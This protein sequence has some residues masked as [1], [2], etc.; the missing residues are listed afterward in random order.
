MANPM[1]SA[2]RA[3]GSIQNLSGLRVSL[4]GA[5]RVGSSLAHWLVARGARMLSI[6]SASPGSAGRLAAE[7]GGEPCAAAGLATGDADLLLVAVPDQALDQAAAELGSRPQAAVALHV[8]GSR[9]ASVL[10]PLRA[11][12]PAGDGARGSAVGTFHPLMAFPTVRRDPRD[13]EGLVFG[14]DA[15]PAARALAERLTAAW[16][17][18]LVEVPAA[19][20][21]LYHYAATLAAGG[22]LTLIARAEEIAES[23]GLPNAVA[24]GYRRLAQSALEAARGG[25]AAAAI[26]GPVARGDGVLV[27]TQLEAAPSALDSADFE[28]HLALETLR[29]IARREALTP[30]QQDLRERLRRRLLG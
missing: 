16:G 17:A 22:V 26:T 3:A 7:L 18:R 9:D 15:D 24:E 29:Q 27:T 20:R 2:T 14:V 8:S 12:G 1:G 21:L 6:A 5:G 4:L 11:G 25:P 13:A 23:A 30:A 10:A 28:T 19:A